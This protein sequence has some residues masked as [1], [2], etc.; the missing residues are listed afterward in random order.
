MVYITPSTPPKRR[1]PKDS[2]NGNSSPPA[3]HHQAGQDEDDRAHGPAAEATVWTMLFSQMVAVLKARRIAM[4]MTAA[5]IEEAKVS[6]TFR[7]R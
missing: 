1:S 2:Q 5:G 4:E 3:D 6:P 7:P